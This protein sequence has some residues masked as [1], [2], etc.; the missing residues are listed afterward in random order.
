MKFINTK[1]ILKIQDKHIITATT[2]IVLQSLKCL[3]SG[4]ESY[5]K[6]TES[7]SISNVTDLCISGV[8]LHSLME[9]ANKIL[10]GLIVVDYGSCLVGA[11]AGIYFSFSITNVN[12]KV[13][14][15][16]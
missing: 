10:G 15:Q 4:L 8:K 9:Y 13:G 7:I 12:E 3:E 2:I 11:V 1:L 16:I 14:K 6:M 5:F